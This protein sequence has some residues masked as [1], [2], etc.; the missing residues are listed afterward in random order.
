MDFLFSQ[1]TVKTLINVLQYANQ[2][3]TEIITIALEALI[4]IGII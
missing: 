4:N 2:K 1:G 3:D